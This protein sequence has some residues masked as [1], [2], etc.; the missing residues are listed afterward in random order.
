M[1]DMDKVIEKCLNYAIRVF[2]LHHLLNFKVK[3]LQTG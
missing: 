3:V 1:L 2:F